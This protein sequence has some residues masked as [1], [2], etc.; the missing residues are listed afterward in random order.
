MKKLEKFERISYI[1]LDLNDGKIEREI[2]EFIYPK[3]VKGGVV[4]IDDYGWNYPELRRELNDFLI[5]KDETL[6]HFP[7]GSSIFI[8]A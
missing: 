6:L 8:K 3:I 4:Y 7:N 5:D 1:S 2:L